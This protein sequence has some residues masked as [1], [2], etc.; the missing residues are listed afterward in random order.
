MLP[1]TSTK[2][3]GLEQGVKYNKMQNEVI[4][5]RSDFNLNLLEQTSSPNLSSF[6][7]GLENRTVSKDNEKV[8]QTMKDLEHQFN[9]KLAEYTELYRTYLRQLTSTD[10]LISKWK[11]KNVYYNPN[12][13]DAADKFN[14]VNKYGY[15]RS[16]SREAWYKLSD[17][18]SSSNCPRTSPSEETS[19]VYTQLQH[20][21]QMGVGEPCGLEGS[22]IRNSDNNKLYWLSP[23]GELHY[24]PDQETWD[25]TIKNGGCP[26][27]ESDLPTSVISTMAM[28]TPMNSASKCDTLNLNNALYHRIASLNDELIEISDKMYNTTH[29]LN[30][31]DE[32]VDRKLV[33]VRE[34]L[35]EK[36]RALNAEREKLN[37]VKTRINTLDGEFNDTSLQVTREY[38]H[39]LVWLLSAVTLGAFA[40]KYIIKS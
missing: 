15:T 35:R 7:E 16:W 22:N 28:G 21:S 26:S 17:E 39:Y 11:G 23:K 29:Q 18:G 2:D 33:G 32:E 4:S 3:Y 25:A 10:E 36:I 34:E 24:Y 5:L 6:V 31:K 38:S 30:V 40:V 14:Y 19:S 12:N 1:K 13:S 8:T 9:E 27:G 20:G 37:N